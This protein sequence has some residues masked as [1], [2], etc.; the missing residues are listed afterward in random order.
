MIVYAS[1][2]FVF[3]CLLKFSDLKS[4]SCLC[5]QLDLVRFL[6]ALP[7]YRRLPRILHFS[8]FRHFKLLL[9]KFSF[10]FIDSQIVFFLHS[11]YF[12]F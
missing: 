2:I 5:M 3:V 11:C 1:E 12:S 8:I 9:L 6:T 10:Q 4:T 7:V